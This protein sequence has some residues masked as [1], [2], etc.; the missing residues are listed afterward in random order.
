M[1]GVLAGLRI[2]EGSAFVAAPLGGMT[3]A[4]LG[5][6]VIRFDAIGGGLDFR[7]WPVTRDGRSLFWAGLN[8]G[9]R[10]IA[11]DIRRP[12]GQ[13]LLTTLICAPGPGRGI[14]LSNFPPRGWLDYDRLRRRREDLIYV[15]VLGDRH[16]GSA[17]DYTVNPRVGFPAM[18]GPADDARPVN[19]VLPAWD[20]IAGQM[21]AVGLLAAERHRS[22][23]GVGQHV[24]I[25]LLDVALASVGHL[26]LLAEASVNEQERDRYGNHLFGGFGHDF[27]TADG[28]RVMVVGLTSRQWAAIVAATKLQAEVAALGQRLG[29]DL[30]EE[31]ERFGA[32]EA[33]RGLIAT[34]VGSRSLAEVAAQ[35]DAND[36]CWCRYQTVRQ[37]VS[38]DSECSERNPLFKRVRQPG[39]GEYLMPAVPIEFSA[40]ERLAPLPAP[41]LGQHTDEILSEAL[42]LS[43]AQIGKLHDAG[44]V[45]GAQEQPG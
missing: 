4:Q 36:V 17:V 35:F 38:E 34:W 16:G 44:I 2:I 6:E 27:A 11:V 15:S 30:R 41:L 9:K 12:E 43:G 23:H 5:A 25:P 14:F 20:N 45:A 42:G 21:A 1:S 3:L 10:S 28:E 19:H 39:V 32:R 18:T 22:L 24:R 29:V 26:G 13:E 31:G 40:V 37:L 8:K 33:L 7:R